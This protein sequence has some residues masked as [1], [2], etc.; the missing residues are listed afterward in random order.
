MNTAMKCLAAV[1]VILGGY[2]FS[3]VA[4]MGQ[5]Y[6]EASEKYGKYRA[7]ASYYKAKLAAQPD[8]E[9]FRQQAI[10]YAAKLDIKVE[11]TGE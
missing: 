3:Y 7:E 11:E 5:G 10:Y 2:Y 9:K 8:Y 4:G 1:I 6:Q